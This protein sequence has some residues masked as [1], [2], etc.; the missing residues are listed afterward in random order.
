VCRKSSKSAVK[1]SEVKCSDV[2]WSGE[3]GN[4]NEF[5]PNERNVKFKWPE[6][7]CRKV[8]SS[9]VKY[10][11]VMCSLSH[12]NRVSIG[13]IE[14]IKFAD[15][16]AFLF[17]TFLHVLLFLFYHCIHNQYNNWRCH[18]V[19]TV[20]KYVHCHYLPNCT[21]TH[22]GVFQRFTTVRLAAVTVDN[23]ASP[24]IV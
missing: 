15:N 17:I 18:Y 19:V 13:Y 4:V 7:E 22:V 10:S 20:L 16:M 24:I 6:M 21:A 1:W 3:V 8:W 23:V 12:S 2:R 9:G 5:K 14:H 11:W